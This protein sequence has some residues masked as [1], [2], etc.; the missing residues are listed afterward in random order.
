MFILP[1]WLLL[2]DRL[3]ELFDNAEVQQE[4]AAAFF[5][6]T[7]VTRQER[8]WPTITEHVEECQAL[9]TVQAG[10]NKL[11]RRARLVAITAGFKLC[12]MDAFM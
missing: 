6:A 2:E 10:L 12:G 3:G 9:A 8:A 7:E 11:A 1:F 5:L 4:L